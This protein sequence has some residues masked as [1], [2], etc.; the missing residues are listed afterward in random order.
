MRDP[1]DTARVKRWFLTGTGRGQVH[2]SVNPVTPTLTDVDDQPGG[3]LSPS[4]RRPTS[5][6]RG[7][8]N[9]DNVYEITVTAADS[10]ANTASKS[11]TVKV[12]NMSGRWE[13]QADD[14]AAGGRNPDKGSAQRPG[15][16]RGRHFRGSGTGRPPPLG[17]QMR[18]HWF[19]SPGD[20]GPWG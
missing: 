20:D 19:Q 11:V 15:R 8:A 16:S 6:L 1:E 7:D 2:T 13:H 10:A 4:S 18:L 3:V 17:S 5:N 12:T 14:V 9:G